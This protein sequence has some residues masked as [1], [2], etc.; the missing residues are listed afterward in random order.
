MTEKS[1]GYGPSFTAAK[2]YEKTSK[3]GNTYL[4]G[5]MGGVRVTALKSREI[6]DDGTAIWSL[7]F[8]EAPAYQPR[9]APHPNDKVHDKVADKVGGKVNGKTGG[10]ALELTRTNSDEYEPV[11]DYQTDQSIPF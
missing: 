7:V 11:G 4:T 5:R 8:A 2:L 6:A 3:N 9:D 1:N 10:K